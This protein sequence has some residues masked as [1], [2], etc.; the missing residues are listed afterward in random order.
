ML[1][2]QKTEIGRRAFRGARASSQ[3]WES[4]QGTCLGQISSLIWSIRK[5]SLKTA[6]ESQAVKDR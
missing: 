6:I 2:L 1:G 5:T 4:R 3:E